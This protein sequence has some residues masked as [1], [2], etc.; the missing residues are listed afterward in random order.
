MIGG[1]LSRYF[2]WRFL[3]A[4]IAVF[5]TDSVTAPAAVAKL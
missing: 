1:T 4:V 3:S 5:S 2:G